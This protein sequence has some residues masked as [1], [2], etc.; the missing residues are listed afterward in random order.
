MS[1]EFPRAEM[2]GLTAQL[3]RWK[4]TMALRDNGNETEMIDDKDLGP[5]EIFH[6]GWARAIL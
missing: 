1:S 6:D 5:G 3:R 4:K 2:Y